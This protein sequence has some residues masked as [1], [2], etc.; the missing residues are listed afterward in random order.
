MD[1]EHP[2]DSLGGVE[3]LLVQKRVEHPAA[4]IASE[5]LQHAHARKAGLN[6]HIGAEV[7]SHCGERAANEVHLRVQGVV[8][9]EQNGFHE[10]LTIDGPCVRETAT[11]A[12][13]I[14]SGARVVSRRARGPERVPSV[15]D[16]D[17]AHGR[18][19]FASVALL[20]ELRLHA[21]VAAVGRDG[22]LSR[23]EIGPVSGSGVLRSLVALLIA[24]LDAVAAVGRQRAVGVARPVAAVVFAV[25]ALLAE[26][27]DA[28]AALELT[29]RVA[30]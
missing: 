1:L 24:V 28:V 16:V 11:S 23:A 25:V 21:A 2:G 12:H 15:R 9:I 14:S 13:R 22:A 8:E 27:L 19:I 26:V 3:A 17:G 30:R 18:T 5:N 29:M 6:P 4:T 20:A 10:A 7:R